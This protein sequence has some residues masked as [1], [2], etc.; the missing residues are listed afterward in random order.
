MIFDLPIKNLP[1]TPITSVASRKRLASTEIDSS[2]KKKS[3]I[4]LCN[5]NKLNFN[6]DK[7]NQFHVIMNIFA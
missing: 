5:G 4:R 2:A 1:T 6:C 7:C 3:Q